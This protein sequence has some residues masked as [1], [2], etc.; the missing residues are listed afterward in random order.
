MAIQKEYREFFLRATKVVTGSKA[1]KETNFPTQ[2]MVTDLAGNQIMGFNRFLKTH[3]PSEDVF[4]K[5]FESLTFKLNPEDTASQDTQGLVRIVTGHNIVNRI[6][7]DIE[8]SEQ[9]TTVVVPSAMPKISA[10]SN[11]TIVPQIRKASDNSIVVSIPAL[12]RDIYYIDYLVSSAATNNLKFSAN[13]FEAF[14]QTSPLTASDIGVTN[15]IYTLTKITIPANTL[16]NDNDYID[17]DIDWD[18]LISNATKIGLIKVFFGNETDELINHQVFKIT[19]DPTWAAAGTGVNFKIKGR[20][21]RLEVDSIFSALEATVYAPAALAVGIVDPAYNI[22]ING[23]STRLDG[24][25][26]NANLYQRQYA[27][28]SPKINFATD[29]TITI[30]LDTLGNTNVGYSDRCSLFIKTFNN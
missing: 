21:T 7:I 9:F 5:L 4:K 6:N 18:K 28:N 19:Y 16:S 14:S 27:K 25:S 2:Y 26:T 15:S 29:Q 17:I 11:I 12:N 8:G 30:V 22:T 1:D 23:N 20:I 13:T 24:A 3:F 10:G